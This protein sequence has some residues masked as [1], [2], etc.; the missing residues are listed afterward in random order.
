MIDEDELSAEELLELER[1]AEDADGDG[2]PDEGAEGA[3]PVELALPQDMG[4][5]GGR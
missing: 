1:V 4:A 3:S 2:L 5:P